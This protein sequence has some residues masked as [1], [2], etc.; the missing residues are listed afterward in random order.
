MKAIFTVMNTTL[1]VVKMRPKKH[2]N[3]NNNHN[4]NKKVQA[5]FPLLLIVFIATK[6]TFIF[7][8]E[9]VIFTR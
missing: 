8:P 2:H 7:T 4:N 3:N 6:I 1:A 5:L 9:F